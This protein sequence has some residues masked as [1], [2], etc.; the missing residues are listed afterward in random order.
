[1]GVDTH[2]DTH[3]A[4][5]C[6]ARG[7]VVSQLQI[8]ATTAGYVQVLAW[9]RQAAGN[10]PVAWAVE[11]TRHYGLGLA[12]HLAAQGEQVSEIDCSRTSG[13]A[14]RARA[15]RSMPSARPANCSHA[16]RP[17]KCALTGTAKRCGC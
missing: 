12:R 13:S 3:T 15:T 11:G 14:G 8:P 1:M 10:R 17:R 2:L 9:A 16:R 7:R 6:D 5:I 4:A